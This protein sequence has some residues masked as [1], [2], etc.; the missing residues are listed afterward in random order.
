MIA[1]IVDRIRKGPRYRYRSSITGRYV[2]WLFAKMNPE[3]TY[4]SRVR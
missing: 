2:T 4:R 1:K 3:T